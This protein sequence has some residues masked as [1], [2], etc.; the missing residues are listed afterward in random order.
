LPPTEESQSDPRVNTRSNVF[1]N[2]TLYV[3]SR[4]FPVRVRNL[5][6]GG[7]LLDGANLPREGTA[8]R[9]RRGRLSAEGELVWQT[10][11]LRGM[12]F[13]T[14]IDVYEWV[15]LKSHA[16]Q[17]RVDKAVA[18]IRR[19]ERQREPGNHPFDIHPVSLETIATTIEQIC[20]RLSSSPTLADDVADELLRL[21]AIVHALR[22][23][24]APTCKL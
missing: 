19:G 10:H 9:L 4:S 17:Q 12:R 2:A 1:L 11:N 6:T 23:L 13:T 24:A 15:Q 5:S 21:D 7:A 14:E 20:E 16:G 18:A 3:G 8:V 22:T